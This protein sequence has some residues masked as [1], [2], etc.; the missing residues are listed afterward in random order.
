MLMETLSNQN[1]IFLFRKSDQEHFTNRA[2]VLVLGSCFVYSKKK[3]KTWGVY[4][5]P[6]DREVA[7]LM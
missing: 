7:D 5:Q 1:L 4:V 3:K 6:F 2:H